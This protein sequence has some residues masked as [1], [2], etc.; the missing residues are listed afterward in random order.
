MLWC[1]NTKSMP[2]D[3]SSIPVIIQVHTWYIQL[4]TSMYHYTFHVLVCTCMYRYIPNTLFLYLWPQFQMSATSTAEQYFVH[5]KYKCRHCTWTKYCSAVY[6]GDAYLYENILHE[7]SDQGD[8]HCNCNYSASDSC[9]VRKI[10]TKIFWVE[11][12]ATKLECI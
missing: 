9:F 2:Q 8:S 5:Y 11:R 10:A 3:V 7:E 1:Y 12:H 4:C 6:E